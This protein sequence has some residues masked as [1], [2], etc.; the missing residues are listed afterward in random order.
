M[1]IFMEILSGYLMS[2]LKDKLAKRALEKGYIE[3]PLTDEEK[4]E[5]AL[6]EAIKEKENMAGSF[7]SVVEA[8]EQIKNRQDSITREVLDMVEKYVLSSVVME[9]NMKK[10]WNGDFE[11]IHYI[12][13]DEK[14]YISIEAWHKS[15]SAYLHV[16]SQL[17][18][19]RKDTELYDLLKNH[20]Y[21][22]EELEKQ[23]EKEDALVA[24]ER[25]LKC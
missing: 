11:Y 19:I 14:C 23:I 2:N 22:N 8:R 15:C 21:L 7:E 13:E 25:I 12:N 4:Y 16:D 24:F 9:W 17:F 20:Y 1:V 10:T 5:L 6:E 3:K 18:T